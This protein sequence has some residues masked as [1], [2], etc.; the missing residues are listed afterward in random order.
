MV[1]YWER[2]LKPKSVRLSG[3]GSVVSSHCRL[4]GQVLG[5]WSLATVGQVLGAWSL[6][7]AGQVVRYW[8][9]GL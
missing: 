5:A 8:E 7:T 4:G 1:R 3:I 9:H 6:A 2:G